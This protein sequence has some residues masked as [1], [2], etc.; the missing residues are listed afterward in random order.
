[1][2]LYKALGRGAVGQPVR[3]VSLEHEDAVKAV[4]MTVRNYALQSG[5]EG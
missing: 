1:M 2:I 3:R 5:K 4:G